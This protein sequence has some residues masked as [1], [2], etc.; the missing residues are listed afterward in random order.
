[1]RQRVQSGGRKR[2]LSQVFCGIEDPHQ[3]KRLAAYL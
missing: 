3:Q 1:M 2:R